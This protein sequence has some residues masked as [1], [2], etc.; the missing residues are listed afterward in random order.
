MSG[1]RAMEGRVVLVTGATGG[2]GLATAEGLA[3]LGATV[4]LSGR[5]RDAA[6]RAVL[7]LRGKLAGS[8]AVDFVLGDLVTKEGV[9]AVARGFVER[10]AKL[11][12]LVNNAGLMASRPEL[13]ADGIETG[14]AVNVLAPLLLTYELRG[15]L[16]RGERP[17]V[18]TVTGGSHP[19]K[20]DLEDLEG[21]SAFV[22]LT[23]YSHHKLAMMAV[24]RALSR[25]IA[26]TVNVCYPG[27][28]VTRMTKSVTAGDM[29]FFM[30]LAWPLFR[31]MMRDDG[32]KS[33]EKAS[34]SSVHLASSP[35][36]EGVT[37]R[38]YD[39][40]SREVPWPAP[41]TDEVC[42]AALRHAEER[43]G[44]DPRAWAT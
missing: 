40:R 14:F 1:E 32:G 31:F 19:A 38:Y 10:F 30:R 27:Q 9:R 5:S 8:G 21:A 25:R 17:R 13:S 44:I 3:R 20:L 39:T 37:G 12:V 29:P 16:A 4:V 33:A 15:H 43:A 24:M 28:A 11:D 42:E 18:V 35:A 6:E 2:I 23:R 34:R 26:P 41:L 36:L 7:E 22:P